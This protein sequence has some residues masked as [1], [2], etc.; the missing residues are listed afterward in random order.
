MVEYS[1]VGHELLNKSQ[2]VSY[3]VSSLNIVFE[4][5]SVKIYTISVIIK[6]N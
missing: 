3:I 6:L 4:I 5:T 2:I 1:T